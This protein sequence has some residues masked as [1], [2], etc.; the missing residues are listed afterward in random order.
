MP[1]SGRAG[2]RIL[3]WNVQWCRGVDGRVDPLRIAAEARRLAD[4][5]VICFQE[6]S[7]NFPQLP[8][9]DGADQVHLLAH[10]LPEY[11]VCFVS[12]VDVPADNGRRSHF[13]NAIFSRLPVGRVLR[14]SLPWPPAADVRSMPRVAIEA[15]LDAP[16][17]PVR[18]ISTHLEYYS[19]EQRAAQIERLREIHAEAC[20][21]QFP[22]AEAGA[23]KS[24]P[25]PPAAILC[26]DFNMAPDNPLHA[27]MT[28]GFAQDAVPRFRDAW[29]AIHPREPHPPTFKIY[30]RDVG[31]SPYF[32]DY[33]FVT[34]DLKARLKTMRV[35]PATQASDH[36]PVIVELR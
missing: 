36:Q 23:F 32:C 7:V 25:R 31:E 2:M 11:T 1:E 22:N 20:G 33:V 14:H 30:D 26:G 19:Q 28:E 16:F 17:G 18:I 6:L 10:A 8:G 3:T 13:G 34:E 12:G 15:V 24:Y 9:N 5:D 29:Q 27:R 21:A 4:A 35:D